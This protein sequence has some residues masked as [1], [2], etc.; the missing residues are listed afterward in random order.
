[1][2]W[3]VRFFKEGKLKPAVEFRNTAFLIIEGYFEELA[4]RVIDNVQI[5][6]DDVHFRY[7]DNTNPSTLR[8][9]TLVT[10]NL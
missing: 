2:I 9:G 8:Q 5:F 7:E 1:M 3:G 10:L 6:F 4:M